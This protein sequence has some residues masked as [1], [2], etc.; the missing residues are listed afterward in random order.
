[1]I[2]KDIRILMSDGV[3]RRGSLEFDDLIQK[4]NV[5]NSIGTDVDSYLIPGLVDVHT[6]GAC[7]YDHTDC[8]IQEMQEIA[9]YYARN[10]TT[11]FLATTITSEE[12][13]LA[14]AMRKIS[15]YTQPPNGARCMG[16]NLEGP[17]F[18]HEKRGAHSAELLKNPDLSMYKRLD[19][20][21]GGNLKLVC[22]SPELPGAI[23]FIREVSQSAYVSLAHS[24]ADYETAMEGYANGATHTTHL[25][26]GMNSFLHREPGIIGAALD[27]HAYVELIC[28][29]YHMHPAIIR[30]TFRMFPQRVCL[31]SDS[32]RCTNLP[33]GDYESGGLAI[34]VINGMAMLRDGGSLAGS[35][36]SLLQA[37]R[38][39]VSFGVPLADAVMAASTNCA[40][41]IGLDDKVGSLTP[42]AYADFIIL[43]SNLNIK[44]VYIN[45]KQ[46]N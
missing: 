1:M 17:F 5:D 14:D 18:S 6:H 39:T 30:A 44:K 41:A 42:G 31:I 11:S 2:I 35:T 24:T 34:T 29:G 15:K 3:F 4:I 19:S 37:V 46:T 9:L 20:L 10:G 36:I 7:G 45:G 38:N 25:F 40:K 22:V 43:D 23:D 21:S 12:E 26:N 32:L 33:D 13:V 8:S 28:D 27:S 16:I